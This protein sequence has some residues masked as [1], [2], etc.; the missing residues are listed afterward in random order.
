MISSRGSRKHLLAGGEGGLKRLV[1]LW[2][3]GSLLAVGG[4]GGETEL[5][6]EVEVFFDGGVR[7]GEQLVAVE[8]RIGTGEEAHRLRFL[9][10]SGATGGEADFAFGDRDAGDRNHADEVEDVD[11][12]VLGHGRAGHGHE[13]VD[14]DGLGGR[15]EG[16]DDLNHLETVFGGF[17]EAEDAAATDRHAGVLHVAD[18]FESVVV[19][20][21]GDDLGVELARGVDIVIVG[22]DSGFLEGFCFFGTELAES[23]ADFHSEVG[24]VADDIEDL[25]EALGAAADSAPG[26]SHAEAGGSI[27]SGGASAFHDVV[28]FHEAIGIDTGLIASGLRAVGAIFGAATG[29]DGEKGAELNFVLGPVGFVNLAG[30]FQQFEKRELVVSVELVVSHLLWRD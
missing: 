20:V 10:E 28:A 26:G 3:G 24:D 21:S 9:G 16:G 4:L 2:R 27:F 7:G 13:L 18:G 19:G 30:L 23:D 6:D 1:F 8:D 11:A 12:L 17:A 5:G 29:F 15:V 22:G 14:G 25:V